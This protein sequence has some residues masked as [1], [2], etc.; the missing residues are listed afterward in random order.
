MELRVFLT[1]CVFC[2][3]LVLFGH[4]VIPAK[5]FTHVEIMI[6]VEIDDKRVMVHLKTASGYFV[7]ASL[8][9]I[10]L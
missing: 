7:K 8:V 1:W 2:V 5:L 3:I 9:L 6:E 4:C 10:K